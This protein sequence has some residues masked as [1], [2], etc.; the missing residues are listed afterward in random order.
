MQAKCFLFDLDGTLIDSLLASE[1]VWTQWAYEHNVLI[2]D[3]LNYIHG[4]QA[5]DSL[6]HFMRGSS[7]NEV[8]LALAD[9][10]RKECN[11]VHDITEI[12]G[13]INF[14]N[15]LNRHK[16]PWAIVTSGTPKLART[17][18][19]AAKLPMPSL[20][21]T[22]EQI[23]NSKPHPE[24]Y[25]LAVNT[26]GFKPEECIVV[27]DALVGIQ[28]GIAAGCQ[29][30]AINN[31]FKNDTNVKFHITSYHQLA[32]NFLENDIIEVSMK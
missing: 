15:K 29:V 8:Q 5:V 26:L 19:Q 30:I 28:S 6:R 25:L 23:K 20:F 3:V 7:E 10:E 18:H 32:L 2:K 16:I 4:R 9:L 1:R 13:A 11:E 21:I 12:D 22:A 24:A 17:R 31:K 27:E 14:L